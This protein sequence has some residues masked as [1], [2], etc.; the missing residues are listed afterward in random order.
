MQIQHLIEAA[1]VH[2]PI[3]ICSSLRAIVNIL[4]SGRAPIRV[5][6]FLAGG[7]LTALIKSDKAKLLLERH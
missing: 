2:L 1:E 3:S 7:S 5:A 6:K 4:A